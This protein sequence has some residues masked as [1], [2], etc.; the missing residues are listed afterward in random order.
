MLVLH[1]FFRALRYAIVC[2]LIAAT[3]FTA[4]RQAAAGQSASLTAMTPAARDEA[5]KGV[6]ALRN[7]HYD[8]AV[9]H[10]R[11]AV[12]LDPASTSAR[13][14]LGFALSENVV[15]GINTPE[16]L[17][18]AQQAIDAFEQVLAK[19]PHNTSCMKQIAGIYFNIG[20]LDDAKAWQKKVLNEDARDAEAAYTVGVID[21]MEAYRNVRAAMAPARIQDDG[22]GNVH[23]P[24]PVM[25]AIK[26]KNAPL[27]EEG[28][29]QKYCDD[30]ATGGSCSLSTRI[31]NPSG[32][33]KTSSGG[34]SIKETNPDLYLIIAAIARHAA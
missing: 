26:A 14:Y 28:M 33:V 29:Q 24:A 11:K 10:F 12:E 6:D 25:A 23:A 32:I 20:K 1:D 31:L 16:N 3:A 18:T 7:A 9:A 21:W 30:W 19:A 34:S 15:P 2:L 17:R 13:F 5:N 4:P 22:A 27:V 8:E